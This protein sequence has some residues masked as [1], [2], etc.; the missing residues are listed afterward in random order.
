M[1]DPERSDLSPCCYV[2]RHR[3]LVRFYGNRLRSPARWSAAALLGHLVTPFPP[4]PRST[5]RTPQN[6][7]R[8]RLTAGRASQTTQDLA[9]R[10]TSRSL[11]SPPPQVED[12]TACCSICTLVSRELNHKP[13]GL[14]APYAQYIVHRRGD[15]PNIFNCQRVCQERA[16]GRCKRRSVERSFRHLV[17]CQEA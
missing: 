16:S 3:T 13:P 8:P 11:A 1:P 17:R 12:R 2:G 4:T 6:E 15:D 14:T 9:N 5:V 7:R 10:T